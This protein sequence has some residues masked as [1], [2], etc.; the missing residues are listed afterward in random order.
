MFDGTDLSMA[1]GSMYEQPSSPIP[2]PV[3]PQQ[4][5]LPPPQNDIHIPI[6]TAS[7]QAPPDFVY[8]PPG[9]MYVQQSGSGHVASTHSAHA[10]YHDTFWDRLGQKKMEVLKLF[11]LSMVV[12]L[13]ISMDK[14][15]THYLSTYI[16]KSFL[17]DLQE[18]LV[19]IS[20]PVAIILLLWI[21]KAAS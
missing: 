20:Y 15:I 19:R 13:G 21:I 2:P 5:P 11:I 16:S 14:V 9:A 12:L 17:S 1:Y 4:A 10:S 8:T 18:L 3:P 6:S 7:H